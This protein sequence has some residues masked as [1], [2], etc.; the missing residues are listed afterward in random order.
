MR[1][2]PTQEHLCHMRTLGWK[3][4]LWFLY[5]VKIIGRGSGCSVLK[6]KR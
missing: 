2:H 4:S 1:G 6:E 5:L 3:Q